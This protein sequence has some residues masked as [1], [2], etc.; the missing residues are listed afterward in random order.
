MSRVPRY[1]APLALG[2]AFFLLGMFVHALTGTSDH[3]LTASIQVALIAGTVGLTVGIIGVSGVVVGA[4]ATAQAG[5]I[6]QTEAQADRKEA[7]EARFADRTRELAA[8]LLDSARRYRWAVRNHVIRAQNARLN[9]GETFPQVAQEL[10]LI[11]RS[12][13]SVTALEAFTD[14]TWRLQDFD[15]E[16]PFEGEDR[17]QFNQIDAEYGLARLAFEG[18]V[19][20]ELGIE[21]QDDR[22]GPS[23][24]T[25]GRGPARRA[26]RFRAS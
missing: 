12:P 25:S 22:N 4:R 26:R 6:S 1:L 20:A 23:Q 19:R 13:A 21:T 17:A 7:R 2:I 5:R 24:P 3:P 8:Q 16:G 15:R 18:A 10:R 9:L 14:A 11:L